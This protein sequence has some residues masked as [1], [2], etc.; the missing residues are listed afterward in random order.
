MTGIGIGVD[1]MIVPLY[2]SEIAPIKVRG[3]MVGFFVATLTFGQFSSSCISYY[4]QGQWRVIFAI[5]AIPALIQ[6]V[7]LFFLP[8]T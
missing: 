1:L 8:E 3:T 7:M 5:G 6:F 4:I 2:L